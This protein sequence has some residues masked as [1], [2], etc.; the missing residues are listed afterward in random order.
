MRKYKLLIVVLILAAGAL[1][2]RAQS[3][4]AL[5]KPEGE[6][7]SNN[8]AAIATGTIEEI[9]TA[10]GKLEP[11]E[12]VD[13]GAQVSGQ[14]EK[15]H[16]E[17]GDIV[18]MG[19]LIAEIDPKV[20]ES[21]VQADKARLR[22]LQ[23][24]LSEQKAQAELARLQLKRNQELIKVNA[25]SRE[26]L[27]DTETA[28][29]VAEARISSLLAQIEEAQSTLNGDLA[30]LSYTKIYAPMA[31]TVVLQ[32]IREGQTI[33]ASQSAPTIVQ[34]ANLDTMTVRAQVAEAD[35]MRLK[36]EMPVYFTTLGALDRRWEGRVRQILP[37]PD[38]VNDV[39]LYNVLVDV[40]NRDRQLMTGMSTQM[41][42]QLGKAE[43]VP[44]IPVS[45]LGKKASPT[46]GGGINAYA[47]RVK[48]GDGIIEK[49]VQIGLMGRTNAE[50]K[51]GLAIGDEVALPAQSVPQRAGGQGRGGFRGG[52]RL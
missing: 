24:Q 27:E 18:K 42:F 1:F 44:L 35:V 36:P 33:N 12:Y 31:G 4:G 45:A 23:A 29:K 3:N 38:V 8:F 6:R 34:L 16:V 10:Q 15:I 20:Y 19:D 7:K 30:N 50:V 52:P 46:D 11:K 26:A 32:N 43:N 13:V 25:I 47:V 51:S 37:A 40:D 17:I 48:N 49:T 2:W 39:V 5:E 14:L 22:T 28:V 9:V 41:F 21:R